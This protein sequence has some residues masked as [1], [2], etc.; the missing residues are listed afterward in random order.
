MT[1]PISKI[2]FGCY[3][4]NT[5]IEQ[6]YNS[7]LKA[8]LEG[9]NLIDTSSNYSM[10]GSE[11][12]VGKVLNELITENKI[13][14][15]DITLVTKG[16]YIQGILL[17]ELKKL[18][19]EGKIFEEVVEESDRLWHCISPDFLEDQL[20]RQ[21]ERLNTPYIDYYLLH[22]PEYFLENA[23]HS[24]PDKSKASEIYYGRIEKAFI[25]LEKQCDTGRIKYYGVSS[26]TF[27]AYSDDPSFTSL[28]RIYEIANSISK[29]NRFKMIQLPLNLFEAGAV[30]IKNQQN[31][32]KTVLEYAADKDLKVIINRP[33]NAITSKGLVRLAD[34][35]SEQL[36]EKDFIKQIKLVKLLEEDLLNEKLSGEEIHE[37]DLKKL[38]SCL[39]TGKQIDE[40]WKF[41]G[42]IEHFNDLIRQLFAPRINTLLDY[43]EKNI[44]DEGAKE[45]FNNYIQNVYRLLNLTGNYYK[46]RSEKRSRFIHGL[47]NSK[48]DPAYHNLTLSQKT[49]LII[50][51]VKGVD[52]VLAGMTRPEYADDLL[53]VTELSKVENAEEI[54]SYVSSE[55]ESANNKTEIS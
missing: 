41:F 53:R 37:E 20:R 5:G 12:L 38:K 10:G 28:E 46:L 6:H 32:T 31:K 54:I 24:N 30:K 47:V 14:R 22:N 2:G 52:C 34:F 51:S 19:E 36:E 26:N 42:S 1:K 3:R 23:A 45:L 49:V 29:S 15:E 50:S 55:I 8:L 11:S 44:S 4:I 18:K 33:L 27:P 39:I 9:V 35:K 21:F 25:Y 43:F 7:L 16:G 48:L 17:N 40:N 13:Q